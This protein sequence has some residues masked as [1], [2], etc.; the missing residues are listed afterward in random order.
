MERHVTTHDSVEDVLIV[1]SYMS[2]RYRQD[3]FHEESNF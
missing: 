3:C 2:R 1:C